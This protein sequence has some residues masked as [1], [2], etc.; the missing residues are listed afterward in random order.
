VRLDAEVDVEE[1]AAGTYVTLGPGGRQ[2]MLYVGMITD[3]ELRATMPALLDTP[4]GPDEDFLQDVYRGTAAYASRCVAG[5]ASAA[6]RRRSSLA[7][8]VPRT[9]ALG[10]STLP[11]ISR[12]THC[13]ADVLI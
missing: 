2:G 10:L 4:P 5:P 9:R 6:P 13:C 7:T 1:M 8:A 11:T 3:I 12:R